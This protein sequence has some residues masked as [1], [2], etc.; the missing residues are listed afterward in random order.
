MGTIGYR[1]DQKYE[2]ANLLRAVLYNVDVVIAR[3]AALFDGNIS[4]TAKA[5]ALKAALGIDDSELLMDALG[6][7]NLSLLCQE[8]EHEW[9]LIVADALVPRLFSSEDAAVGDGVS[10]ASASGDSESKRSDVSTSATSSSSATTSTAVEGSRSAATS[11]SA[12]LSSPARQVLVK[13]F[14]PHKGTTARVRTPV[15][16]A[17]SQDAAAEGEELSPPEAC[18][19]QR[20]ARDRE[21]VW[22]NWSR[23]D[24][25]AIAKLKTP[26]PPSW[27]LAGAAAV[28][29]ANANA[30]ADGLSSTK[31]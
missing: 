13:Q 10:V 14:A 9:E 27:L 7:R 11:E 16:Y 1:W 17:A 2:C 23:F 22:S 28:G 3:G 18:S 5:R 12:P 26:P 29:A 24:D 4:G 31:H 8:T 21:I 30:G 15:G 19:E 25:I 6:K 20:G